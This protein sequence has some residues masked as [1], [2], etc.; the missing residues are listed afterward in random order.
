M[1]VS[2]RGRKERGRRREKVLPKDAKRPL[3]EAINEE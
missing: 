2:C 1:E 3:Q